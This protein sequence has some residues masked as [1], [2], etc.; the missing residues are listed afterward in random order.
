VASLPALGHP[1]AIGTTYAADLNISADG[2]EHSGSAVL[3]RIGVLADADL[4]PSEWAGAT[5][6]KDRMAAV[7]TFP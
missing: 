1:F 4:E 2:S 3:G 7:L 5:I 6:A